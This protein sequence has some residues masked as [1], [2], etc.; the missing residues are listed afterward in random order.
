MSNL[1]QEAWASQLAQDKNAVV[2]D[3][4]TA[5]E[6]EETGYIPRMI[7]IDIYE[8]PEFI[9]KI[10][11][12]DKSKNYYVYCRSGQRSGQACALMNSKGFDNVFN[13]VGGMLEWEGD[14]EGLH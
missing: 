4:R 3:V 5:L 10:E 11:A 12:L 13:L 14:R 2:I 1:T 8:G 9:A 7:H 6:L